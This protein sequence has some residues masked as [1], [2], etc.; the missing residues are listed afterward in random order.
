[1]AKND[2]FWRFLTIFGFKMRFFIFERFVNPGR[3]AF[4][5]SLL[6]VFISFSS[7]QGNPIRDQWVEE[8]RKTIEVARVSLFLKRMSSVETIVQRD[9]S[10]LME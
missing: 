4:P 1:M 2:H 5:R 10:G 3:D 7:L 6:S 9:K 8:A